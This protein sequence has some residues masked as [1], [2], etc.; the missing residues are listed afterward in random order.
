MGD[1]LVAEARGHSG[2]DAETVSYGSDGDTMV[3]FSIACSFGKDDKKKTTWVNISCFGAIAKGQAINVK[4]GTFVHVKGN[5]STYAYASKVDGKPVGSLGIIANDVFIIQ[6]HRKV[7]TDPT[8]VPGPAE[9]P[10]GD[11]DSPPA[12]T[13]GGG[14]F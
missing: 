7:D 2:G 14:R 11:I 9:P 6:W 10:Q 13:P 3:K 1:L 5:P 12:T 8:D 4:K